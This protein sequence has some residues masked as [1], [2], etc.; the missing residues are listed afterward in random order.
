MKIPPME[1]EFFMRKH[2]RTDIAKLIVAFRNFVS[3]SKSG[4]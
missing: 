4:P 2:G 3:V 1:A